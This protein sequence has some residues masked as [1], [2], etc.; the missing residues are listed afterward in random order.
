M[1]IQKLKGFERMLQV[2]GKRKLRECKAGFCC[3]LLL[4]FELTA[5]T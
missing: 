1:N 5:A 3:M 4:D 2:T